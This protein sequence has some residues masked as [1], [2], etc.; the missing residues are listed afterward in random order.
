MAGLGCSLNGDVRLARTAA[1]HAFRSIRHFGLRV[2]FRRLPHEQL[3]PM[4]ERQSAASGD[5]ISKDWPKLWTAASVRPG[6][7]ASLRKHWAAMSPLCMM[8]RFV[9]MSELAFS[10]ELGEPLWN[11]TNR[12]TA[13]PIPKCTAVRSMQ[14][15]AT[16]AS[17]AR[18]AS[19]WSK[20][21]GCCQ[22]ELQRR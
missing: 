19:S 7:S 4:R 3:L 17:A 20:V 18:A 22:R 6:P 16:G 10:I 21:C 15:P 12:Q 2:R 5:T 1:L 13:A 8:L 14:T 11:Q 9:Q